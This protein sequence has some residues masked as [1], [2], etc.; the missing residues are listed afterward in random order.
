MQNDC[1]PGFVRSREDPFQGNSHPTQRIHQGKPQYLVKWK[2]YE[3]PKD[4]TWE[5]LHHLE[6]VREMVDAFENRQVKKHEQRE[7]ERVE[8]KR[9][10]KL[11]KR[12]PAPTEEELEM[13]PRKRK[14]YKEEE[15]V[16]IDSE[17]ESAEVSEPKRKIGKVGRVNF[18]MLKDGNPLFEVDVLNSKN[19]TAHVSLI[20]SEELQKSNRPEMMRFM[21]AKLIESCL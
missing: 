3:D 20:S 15:A 14:T 21:K 16:L 1:P 17:S 8:D 12:V 4:R 6:T 7:V 11:F 19:K 5:P 18:M 13:K 2:N 9:E 10:E